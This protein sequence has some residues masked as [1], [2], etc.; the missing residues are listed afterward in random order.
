MHLDHV[1]RGAGIGRDDRRLAPGDPVE[2]RR[3]AGIGRTGDRHHQAVAQSLAAAAVG[4]RG[5]DLVLPDSR[6]TQ[7]P[8]PVRSFGTS[9]SSE[10]SMRASTNASASISRCRQLSARLPSRPFICRNACR[11]WPCVSAITRSARPSTAVRSSL[12]FS[13]ARRVNSP[14]S[15]GRKPSIAAERVAAPRRS[16]RGR[17]AAAARP[18]PRR[19]RSSGRKPQDER[20]VDDLV[21]ARIADAPERGLARLRDFAAER[22]QR[23]AR[24]RAG[25]ADDRDGRGRAAGGE[26]EDGVGWHGHRGAGKRVPEAGVKGYA[27][28]SVSVVAVCKKSPTTVEG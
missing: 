17:R 4:E 1:A 16:P 6:A 26:G 18:R 10:K 25:D 28:P 24:A 5:R 11:R 13:K 3:L 20:L 2:Q 22:F 14:A 9:A 7:A 8:A 12:P 15:A 21:I 19:S 23:L 27:K